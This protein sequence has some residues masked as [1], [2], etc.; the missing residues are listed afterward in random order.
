MNRLVYFLL[1]IL[2]L[3]GCS[4][5]QL[6]SDFNL[7]EGKVAEAQKILG[8]ETQRLSQMRDSLQVK[9]QQNLDLG[10][11]RQQ[12]EEIE[13]SLL[14]SQEALVTAAGLNLVRQQEY[15]K[16]LKTQQIAY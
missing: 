12:A 11:S 14:N 4:S 1:T 3:S 15:L 7:Q 6:E 16:Q 13:N 2:T 9:I 8:Q 10:L 5:N